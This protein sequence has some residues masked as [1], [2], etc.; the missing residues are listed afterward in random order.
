[1]NLKSGGVMKQ[2]NI[3]FLIHRTLAGSNTEEKVVM[4]MKRRILI[5]RGEYNEESN[6]YYSNGVIT[7]NVR[8]QCRVFLGG[9][10]CMVRQYSNETD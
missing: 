7:N 4:M 5:E 6:L 1:M 10:M 3:T 8:M 2:G 9:A